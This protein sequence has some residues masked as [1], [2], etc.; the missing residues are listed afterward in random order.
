MDADGAGQFEALLDQ[1]HAPLWRYLRRRTAEADDVLADTLAVLWR[2]R[3][4]VPDQPLPWAYAVARG[5]L[6]NADR[7]ARRRLSLVQ[8]L[9]REPLAPAPPE[10]PALAAALADLPPADQEVLRLWAWEQLPAREIALVLGITPNAASIRLHRA[11]GRLR[12]ALLGPPVPVGGTRK[13]PA[14]PGHKQGDGRQEEAR[15]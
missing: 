6:Q 11:T 15:P 3:D 9:V 4:E 2:R 13:D 14:R 8:R 7:S 10:D 5:C 1:V 12:T